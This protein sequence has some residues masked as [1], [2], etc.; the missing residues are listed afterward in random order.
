MLVRNSRYYKIKNLY[1]K[2]LVVVFH[3]SLFINNG[4]KWFSFLS[5]YGFRE[6]ATGGVLWKKGFL[7]I[8]QTLLENTYVRA[9]FS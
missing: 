3:T 6:T 2:I 7:K 8:L 9:L 4:A 5:G 1:F